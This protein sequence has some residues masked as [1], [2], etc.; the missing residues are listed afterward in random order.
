MKENFSKFLKQIPDDFKYTMKALGNEFRF[1]LILLLLEEESFSLSKLSEILKKKNSLIIGH[2]KKLELAGIVQNY[3]HHT[4][5]KR[6]YSFYEITKYG[7]KMVKTIVNHYNNLITSKRLEEK[8]LNF[9]EIPNDV[10]KIL[11]A[12]SN[13]FR[14]SLL[15]FFLQEQKYSFT[16]IVGFSEKSKNSIAN[17]L[18]MMEI[19][20]LIQNFYEKQDSSSYSFYSITN[21]G[22]SLISNLNSS[23][24]DYYQYEIEKIDKLES[25]RYIENH[26]NIFCSEWG[27]PN[28]ILLG[29][30]EIYDTSVDKIEIKLDYD[31]KINTFFDF[32]VDH[33]LDD[34]IYSFD[35]VNA[36]N[37]IPFEFI[38]KIPESNTPI[39]KRS[40]DV[41]VFDAKHNLLQNKTVSIE[42]LRPVVKLGVIKR[43]VSGT[44]GIFEIKI[45]F[46]SNIH[47]RIPSIEFKVTDMENKD[48]RIVVIDKDPI[49]INQDLRPGIDLENLIGEFIINKPGIFKIHFR[50]PYTDAANN[51]Y[52]S[53]KEIVEIG[54]V[55]SFEGNLKYQYNY[56]S[57]VEVSS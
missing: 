31:L 24:N 41:S 35:I 19:A 26:F 36:I 50:I 47:I 22:K 16:E 17:H 38:S 1:R 44:S 37:Y 45:S 40:L 14:L 43:E 2:L 49:E 51:N 6:E 20:G 8:Y 57:M 12:L 55:E 27:L 13:Q 25:E 15:L 21:I 23:Y 34:N 54:N 52:Y 42:I 7:E 28:E 5:K 33:N 11:K 3:I 56:E 18:K 10:V 30:I 32:E 48:I 29:W 46:L 53:N 4:T 9:L 39:N